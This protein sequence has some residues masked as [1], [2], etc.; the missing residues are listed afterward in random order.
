MAG[1]NH[2]RLLREFIGVVNKNIGD[3]C[4]LQ[5]RSHAL[6]DTLP[7]KNQGIVAPVA[8]AFFD[9]GCLPLHKIIKHRNNVNAVLQKL[10]TYAIV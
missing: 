3:A 8:D 1:S 10:H 9:G 6:T 2:K 5:Q 7:V 4:F